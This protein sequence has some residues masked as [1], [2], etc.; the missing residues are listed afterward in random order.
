MTKSTKRFK[1]KQS[2]IT[3]SMKTRW[4]KHIKKRMRKKI[5]ANLAKVFIHTHIQAV[6]E[7]ENY[8]HKRKIEVYIHILTKEPEI[9]ACGTRNGQHNHFFLPLF[10]YLLS[11]CVCVSVCERVIISGKMSAYNMNLLYCILCYRDKEVDNNIVNLPKK[12]RTTH[13]NLPNENRRPF[14][15]HKCVCVCAHLVIRSSY[16]WNIE[17][18]SGEQ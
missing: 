6:C 9:S 18:N 7:E 4:T 3:I 2:I 5:S 17:S 8:Y 13:K 15:S 1:D 10:R 12:V 14:R 11:Q 16:D